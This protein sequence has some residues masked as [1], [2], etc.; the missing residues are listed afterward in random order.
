MPRR[1]A[2]AV[3]A[4]IYG[5]AN[6]AAI[7]RKRP[8]EFHAIF[9]TA[10]A[11]NS[12]NGI[13]CRLAPTSQWKTSLVF[14]TRNIPGA[15]FR[16]LSAFALRDLN[17]T[18]IESRPL[19]G[20][21][22]E[23]LFYLD[24]LG[25]WT[26]PT[27]RNALNHLRESP[28]SCACWAATP[29]ARDSGRTLRVACHGQLK[30]NALTTARCLNARSRNAVHLPEPPRRIAGADGARHRDFSRRAAAHHGGPAQFG[31]AGAVA[32]REPHAGG[33][34][35]TRSARGYAR[36]GRSLPGRHRVRDA[37]GHP[38][39]QRQSAAVLR[40]HRRASARASSP[41]PS[42]S[43]ARAWSAFRTSSR[44]SRPRWKRCGRTWSACSSRS[45][46]PR[47]ISPTILPPPPTQHHRAGQAGRFRRRQPAR[48]RATPSASS[49]SKQPDGVARL[50]EIHRHLTRELEL[51]ELRGRIQSQ[52]Q[53]QLSQSQREFYLREQL[54]AIQKELG[55][56]D[57]SQR[58][59]EELREKLEAAGMPEEV[60]TEAHA[61]TEPAGAHVAGLARIRRHAHLPGVDGQPAVE[62]LLRRRRWT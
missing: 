55:E 41:P 14:S 25:A 49:C 43:C 6:S 22:W 32:G 58:D 45:W 31:R 61:R 16:A 42:R 56:G 21:P 60:K 11:R 38:R 19:R 62:H 37:Q 51:L 26:L 23:Y 33:G 50:N 10:H 48:A 35:A 15:L 8:A 29:K 57:E 27:R 53:G 54:K 36:P 40:G 20:K 9:S 59:I 12:P 34:L 2:S 47:R 30:K 44:R 1:I 24:F 5:G 52:V 7:H 18:K 17:L 46:P 28:T 13:P 4:E 3:A 39:A